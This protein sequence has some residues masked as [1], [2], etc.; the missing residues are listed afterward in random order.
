MLFW[1]FLSLL[2][3]HGC[4]AFGVSAHA[5]VWF[6]L[7]VRLG[8]HLPHTPAMR[9]WLHK[10]PVFLSF[11]Q[12]PRLECL[13]LPEFFKSL[14]I[15]RM[16]FCR[17]SFSSSYVLLPPP[18]THDSFCGSWAFQC[19]LMRSKKKTSKTQSQLRSVLTWDHWLQCEVSVFAGMVWNLVPKFLSAACSF[20]FRQFAVLHLTLVQGFPHKHS[21]R[22]CYLCSFRPLT[23]HCLSILS[24]N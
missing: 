18:K 15:P 8:A 11:Q 6:P 22:K 3:P 24:C 1:S 16:L 7:L 4:V 17:A 5:S 2:S 13:E 19:M 23:S 21:S 14:T 9:L 20:M 10:P 12:L